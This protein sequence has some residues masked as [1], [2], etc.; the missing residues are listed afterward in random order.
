MV[1]CF[2]VVLLLSI[3]SSMFVITSNLQSINRA[4]LF[5]PK[6]IF[7][8]SIPLVQ[9]NDDFEP[10]FDKDTLKNQLTSYYNSTVKKYCHSYDLN[11]YYF[12]LGSEAFCYEEKCRGVEVSV[13][14][15]VTFNYKYQRTIRYEIRKGNYGN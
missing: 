14:A 11:I 8:S 5:T 10:Y 9:Q 4:V 12:N 15:Y 1:I 6:E 2:I 7:E 13:T 3:S